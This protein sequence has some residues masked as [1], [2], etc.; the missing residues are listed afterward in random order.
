MPATYE[1]LFVTQPWDSTGAFG[2]EG[3]AVGDVMPANLGNSLGLMRAAD[4]PESKVF[5][6]Y[7]WVN[8]SD[9]PALWVHEHIHEDQDEVLLWMGSDPENPKDLGAH[10]YM[11]VDGER[12][13]ITTTGSVY[14]PAGTWHC[15]LG[16]DS[17]TRP[18]RF[19]SL[20]L[21]PE[22]VSRNRA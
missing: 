11:V 6:G 22:Y 1:R 19:I 20:F 17:V 16:W 18:F 12:H 15:P 10:V 14:I 21:N 9:D 13:D 3:E 4:V 8:P 7:C 2:N 5:M